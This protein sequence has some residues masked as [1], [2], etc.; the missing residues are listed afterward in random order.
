MEQWEGRVGEDAFCSVAGNKVTFTEQ[1]I[2]VVW[3]MH[4]HNVSSLQTTKYLR[5]QNQGGS[6]GLDSQYRCK[7]LWEWVFSFL[8][9]LQ[10]LRF[11]GINYHAAAEEWEDVFQVCS[12]NLTAC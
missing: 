5:A 12:W 9:W 8:E 4:V 3:E 6:Q 11:R 1:D 10:I 7:E 2:Y